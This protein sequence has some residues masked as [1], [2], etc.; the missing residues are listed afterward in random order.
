M[1]F[2]V[3]VVNDK[4]VIDLNELK[5]D[6]SESYGYDGKPSFYDIGELGCAKVVGQIE[7]SHYQLD[8][9]LSQ[10]SNGG[11]CGWCG[12]TAS[13]LSHPHM[14]DPVLGEKMCRNC[15]EHDR[16]VYLGSYGE[17]IGDFMP[18]KKE[19]K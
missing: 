4:L 10:Y 13:E 1:K 6:Y 9:I 11:E 19:G 14:F 8:R 5:E 17:D 3:K 18:Y 15:W 7:L 16:E 12:E 2:D